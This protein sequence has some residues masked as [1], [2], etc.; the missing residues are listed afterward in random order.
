MVLFTINPIAI[1]RAVRIN[2]EKI[3]NVGDNSPII[4]AIKV[5][6][7]ILLGRAIPF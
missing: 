3:G 7:V 4:K 6:K 5:K 1:R 2:I